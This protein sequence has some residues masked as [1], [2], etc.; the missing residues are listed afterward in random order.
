[1]NR[2]ILSTTY[3]DLYADCAFLVTTAWAQLGYKPTLFVV[4]NK[5]REIKV[6]PETEV[7]EIKSIKT[8]TNGF[9][10]QNIRMIA[11]LWFL[12]DICITGDIDM[13]PMSKEYFDDICSHVVADNIVVASSDAYP[14][15]SKRFPICYFAGYG[16]SYAGALDIEEF[17]LDE[18]WLESFFNALKSYGLG[19]DT[20]EL[21]FTA[22]LLGQDKIKT[23]KLNRG[24]VSNHY[25]RIASNRIDRVCWQ[26][27]H[28]NWLKTGY[29]VDAHLPR[30]YSQNRHLTK[31]IEEKYGI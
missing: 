5:T 21:V 25:G 8:V 6:A 4:G 7:I 18:D 28:D 14:E 17:T 30:P 12:D 16:K 19:W 2:V 26:E 29:A 15:A 20:D 31:K 27:T 22:M 3:D 11:P 10:S 13:V 1:M 9:V 24:W 23:T